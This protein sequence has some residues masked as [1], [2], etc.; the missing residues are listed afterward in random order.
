VRRGDAGVDIGGSVMVS[1]TCA[2]CG[3]SGDVAFSANAVAWDEP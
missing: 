2:E 3:V 1:V